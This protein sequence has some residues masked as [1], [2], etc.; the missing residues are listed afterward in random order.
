[1]VV[2]IMLMFFVLQNPNST[3]AIVLSLIPFFTPM[4]MLA[5]VAI[6]EPPWWQVLFSIG[7]LLVTIY[8]VI[9]FSARVFR[10]G[11]L[12]YGKRPS[13]REILRWFKYA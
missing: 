4:L 6:S 12:M 11:I 5:R 13:L 3:F 2:P 10:A 8:G 7:L 9:L 1:M